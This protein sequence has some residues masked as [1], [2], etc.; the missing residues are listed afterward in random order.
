MTLARPDTF[1]TQI[2]LTVSLNI[3]FTQPE[4]MAKDLLTY[5]N[6]YHLHITGHIFG[7]S[8]EHP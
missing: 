6:G 2:W 5:I 1:V 3:E 8:D 7:N 4:L